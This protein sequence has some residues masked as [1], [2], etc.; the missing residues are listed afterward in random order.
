MVERREVVNRDDR[1][2]AEARRQRQER[3][4]EEVDV[5]ARQPPR[6]Q[7]LLPE[8][9]QRRRL[10]FELDAQRHQ[11]GSG[12]GLH[13]GVGE[14]DEGEVAPLRQLAQELERVDADAGGAADQRPQ[15]DADPRPLVPGLDELFSSSGRAPIRITA[16]G[17]IRS[18]K[19]TTAPLP[20][21]RPEPPL[22]GAKVRSRNDMAPSAS[23]PSAA[24]SGSPRDPDRERVAATLEGL[25]AA[26]R[27]RQ[28]EAATVG[29]GA[30]DDLNGLLLDLKRH[31][32]VEEPVPVSPR[33]VLGAL[34]IF[35]RKVAYHL[36][37]KWHARGV[38][39]QQNGFNQSAARLIE[40]LAERQR[41]AE[42]EIGRLRRERDEASKRP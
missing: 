28:G 17:G 38:L 15:V 30:G 29:G 42:E 35:A 33:P 25:R 39:A 24:T 32:F 22:P 7:E 1:R 34:L 20:K 6:Q 9:T 5:A 21:G 41:R 27:Q 13:G 26:V 16:D 12:G 3:R 8:N 18:R 37:F 40:E 4:P 2:Q 23:T 31:E 14:A 19:C 36:F 11:L 10:D